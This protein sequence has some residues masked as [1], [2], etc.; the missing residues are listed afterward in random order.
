MEGS[1]Q[2]RFIIVAFGR[3]DI[4]NKLNCTWKGMKRF[5]FGFFLNA[6]ICLIFVSTAT[7]TDNDVLHL[8]Q[9]TNKNAVGSFLKIIEDPNESFTPDQA[10]RLINEGNITPENKGIPN[11]MRSQSVYWARLKVKNTFYMKGHFVLEHG[12]TQT[13]K[14]DIYI[15]QKLEMVNH[16]EGGHHRFRTSDS[17]TNAQPVF[18]FSV[19][20][21]EERVLLVKLN[22][23]GVSRFQF[24]IFSDVEFKQYQFFKL[25]FLGAFYGVLLILLLHNAFMFFKTRKTLYGIYGLFVFFNAFERVAKDG[26]FWNI[27]EPVNELANNLMLVLSIPLTFIFLFEFS[28]RALLEIEPIP[29]LSKF[30]QF[31]QACSAIYILG[32]ISLPGIP[33][34]RYTTRSLW[35]LLLATCFFILIRSL[36]AKDG[37]LNWFNSGWVF[38]MVGAAIHYPGIL[39]KSDGFLFQYSLHIATVFEAISFSLSMAS[40]NVQLQE[41]LLLQTEDKLEK[42]QYFNR[43]LN[44][45]V[46]KKTKELNH[47]VE[48]LKSNHISMQNLYTMITHQIRT[49]VTVIKSYIDFLLRGVQCATPERRQFEMME[50]IKAHNKTIE[51]ITE[52]IMLLLTFAPE[53]EVV[54]SD[55]LELSQVIKTLLEGF[56]DIFETM[57]VDMNHQQDVID[58]PKIW[59]EH[60]LGNFIS[61]AIKYGKGK[62][63]TIRTETIEGG[64]LI[65]V[66]DLGDGIPSEYHEKVFERFYR[67]DKDSA[68]PGSG[69]GLY[70]A[71]KLAKEI[72]AQI[73]VESSSGEGSRFWIKLIDKKQQNLIGVLAGE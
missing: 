27:L 1:V 47:S 3:D 52:N 34:A 67:M 48:Q 28:R 58:V 4:K 68:K 45:E 49:P 18:R 50:I 24:Q 30:I 9:E 66:Q 26:F 12:F 40:R 65:S 43:I 37:I 69:V 2:Y 31:S 60:I 61:N 70:I 62:P 14:I 59:L 32:I 10:L 8:D 71:R 23:K 57:V 46:N 11:K 7:G 13:E 15:Y 56:H 21:G 17:G 5:F 20:A 36:L 6:F 25:L 44:E 38:F 72:G 53:E 33:F 41:T 19:P 22:T 54:Q 51:K 55:E 64:T 73:G 63:I 35:F 16:L 29:V 39:S 42:E